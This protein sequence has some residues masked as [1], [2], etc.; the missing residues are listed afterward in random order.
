VRTRANQNFHTVSSMTSTGSHD[1]K[2]DDECGVMND[3]YH[4][5]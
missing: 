2:T 1:M 5:A 3:E 4:A